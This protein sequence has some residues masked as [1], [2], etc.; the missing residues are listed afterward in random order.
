MSK[1]AKNTNIIKDNEEKNKIVDAINNHAKPRKYDNLML[2]VSITS[3]ILSFIAII[4]AMN[5]S[6]TIAES[7]NK[8][9]L[10]EKRYD[11]YME[12]NK[13]NEYVMD[14]QTKLDGYNEESSIY[15]KKFFVKTINPDY[16]KMYEGQEFVLM[17]YVDYHYV[18]GAY[19]QSF[20]YDRFNE[21]GINNSQD[22]IENQSILLLKYELLFNSSTDENKVQLKQFFDMYSDLVKKYTAFPKDDFP[23]MM[24]EYYKDF[25]YDDIPIED[26]ENISNILDQMKKEVSLK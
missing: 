25:N 11:V 8:I 21:N 15:Q 6:K 20:W 14:V 5:T 24:E 3:I 26:I 10:F 9:S 1:N 4:V 7:Q 17:N 23:Q 18:Y 2:G 19:I 22:I 13:I 12:L 16:I